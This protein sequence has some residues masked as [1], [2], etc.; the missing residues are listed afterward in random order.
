MR[1]EIPYSLAS[2]T[3]IALTAGILNFIDLAGH[4]TSNIGE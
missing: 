4:G 2:R 1:Y 3:A